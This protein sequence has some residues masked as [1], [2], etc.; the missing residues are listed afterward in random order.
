MA[1]DTG[2]G[3]RYRALLA[4]SSLGPPMLWA[5]LARMPIYL[6]ALALVLAALESGLGSRRGGVLL[7]C[8]TVG[9]AICAP[10]VA[11]W[12]DVR[13]QTLSLVATTT[14]HV[15]SIVL[16]V[17]ADL[18]G[19]PAGLVLAAVAGASVPP[20]SV[21]IRA[22]IGD[23]DVP[24]MA[25]HAGFAVEAVVAEII[26][27]S[28]PLL[29]SLTLVFANARIALLLGAVLTGLGTLGLSLAPRS[30]KAHRSRDRDVHSKRGA[31]SST[32]L[33]VLLLVVA[34]IG[35]AIGSYTLLLPVFAEREGA[36]A[37]S[38]LLFAVWGMSS[39]L[40][41]LWYGGRATH[42]APLARRYT[43]ALALVVLGMC[44]PPFAGSLWTLS[45]ALILGGCVIAP[46]TALQYQLVQAVAR[47]EHRAEAYAW[48]LSA[49]VGG[50][51]AGALVVGSALN[52]TSVRFGFVLAAGLGA[53][54]LGISTVT[55]R[56]WRFDREDLS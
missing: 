44:L 28:G 13:G 6:T 14:V 23:D 24:A 37:A 15:C 2:T 47:T 7:A 56:R 30:R 39:A 55:V 50:T 26:V 5:A 51:S 21:C 19:S 45:A 27:I 11:R 34:T 33:R 22:I 49:N 41:G 3:A 29:L 40:G 18:I 20:V 31:L 8:Y 9:G 54:S 10:A 43:R 46:A 38:G 16:L 12:I 53:L 17:G 48:V 35:A 52:S 25:Q 1:T 36:S 42:I 32:Q 4:D